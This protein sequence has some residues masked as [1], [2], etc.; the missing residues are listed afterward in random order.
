[1]T[2]ESRLE[3]ALSWTD[4]F[5]DEE[6]IRQA[7]AQIL[8]R[9]PTIRE[10]LDLDSAW[11]R[12]EAALPESWEFEVR[13]STMGGWRATAHRYHETGGEA[14]GLDLPHP[15]PVAALNALA[16]ALETRRVPA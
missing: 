9:D 14:V 15:T 1:M 6:E 13:S 4:Y 10:A 7:R 11:R 16:D 12:V 8:R 3:V 2:A 5:I